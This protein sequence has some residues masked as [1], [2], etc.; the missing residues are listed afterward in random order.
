MNWCQPK[1]ILKRKT[2]IENQLGERLRS[3]DTNPEE[4]CNHLI[5]AS[6]GGSLC[7]KIFK[8]F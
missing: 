1:Q 2:C 7:S 8:Q 5:H 3:R 4:K 6:M